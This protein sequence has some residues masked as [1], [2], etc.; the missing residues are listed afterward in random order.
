MYWKWYWERKFRSD[1]V[2][3][4]KQSASVMPV[5]YFANSESTW[6]STSLLTFNSLWR[7]QME[8]FSALLAICLGY[9]P[10]TSEFPAPRPATRS[11]GV[12]FDLWLNKPLSKQSG[13]WWLQTPLPS[14]W[15]HCYVI[16]CI[17]RWGLCCFIVI[18]I[19]LSLSLWWLGTLNKY[20]I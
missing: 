14:L 8:T 7:H 10:V 20:K 18:V 12:F 1:L 4:A 15:R 11:F 16:I 13:G 9:S 17:D 5:L 3:I 19:W 6:D 2:L